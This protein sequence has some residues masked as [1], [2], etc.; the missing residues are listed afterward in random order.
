M[1]Q[2]EAGESKE[3]SMTPDQKLF[4]PGGSKAR[5]NAAGDALRRGGRTEEDMEVLR[6]WRAAHRPVLHA[7]YRILRNRVGDGNVIVA[8]RYKCERTIVDKLRRLPRMKLSQMN[9]V[10]GCRLIFESMDDLREFRAKMFGSRLAHELKNAPDR[11]D[12]VKS[13][14]LSGYRG[15]H[16]VY[17]CGSGPMRGGL[18][19]EV[20]YRTRVQHDW[21]TAVEVVGFV[22]DSLPKF[23]RGDRGFLEIFRCA[24]GL[25]ARA[26]ENERS[27]LADLDDAEVVR[28]FDR[29]DSELGFLPMLE[30]LRAAAEEVP[31]RENVILEFR[32]GGPVMRGF[33]SAARA[34]DTLF[35]LEAERPDGDVVLVRT[36]GDGEARI[37][38]RN[39]F[40]DARG[41]VRR[42]REGR[43]RLLAGGKERL[44]R[45]G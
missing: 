3:T 28:E 19:V 17:L 44:P 18:L 10:A 15:V 27:C 38:F 11:Y 14:K 12:Y 13:P 26:F 23:G 2:A 22:T 33:S 34:L 40:S 39:Y 45:Q 35:C 20:Q 24:S 37:A 30:G 1:S 7:F 31:A 9:D 41:F 32:E 43:S 6:A 16:D 8:Q 21:A 29:L 42:I 36:A 5:V 25:L 4:Y